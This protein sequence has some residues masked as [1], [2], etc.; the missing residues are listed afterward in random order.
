MD[1]DMEYCIHFEP[2]SGIDLEIETGV[3]DFGFLKF[4]IEAV[5][6]FELE[7][8]NFL[9]IVAEVVGIIGVEVADNIEE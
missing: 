6:N 2:N 5:A 8:L 1:F 9:E 4:G 3:V 7:V